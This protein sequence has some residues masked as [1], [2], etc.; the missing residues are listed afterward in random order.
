MK[1]KV[2]VFTDLDGTL[3]DEN[4]YSAEWALAGLHD[5]QC[6]GVPV[7]FCSSKTRQE[8]EFIR[9]QLGVHDPFIVENGSAIVIPPG[10]VAMS[11]TYAEEPDGT[12]IVILGMRLSELRP[13]LAQVAAESGVA[14]RSFFDLSPEQVVHLTG[15][16]I[17]AASRA[18]AREYSETIVTHFSP[19]Q[20]DAFERKIQSR[21]LHCSHG[22]RFLSVTRNGANKGTAVQLVAQLYRAKSANLITVAIGDSPNDTPMLHAVDVPFLVQRPNG[23]WRRPEIPNLRLLSA[24][25]PH[26]FTAMAKLIVT[27]QF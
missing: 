23:Q 3:L 13:I 19:A 12:R 21:G 20:L 2:V 8:Q 14:Y 25:G 17:E 4:T 5:L 6:A 24:I 15:L 22:G 1:P 7:V 18:K 16:D 27:N 10:T 11:D 26:G 9:S